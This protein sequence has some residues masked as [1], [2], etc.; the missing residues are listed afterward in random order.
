MRGRSWRHG[1][2]GSDWLYVGPGDT[3]LELPG[4]GTDTASIYADFTLPDNVE[5]LVFNPSGSAQRGT[6]NE[7]ANS[8]T[9]YTGND[10][11]QGLG[12]NDTLSGG[13]GNDTLDGGAGIDSAVISGTR[14]DFSVLRMGDDAYS[15]TRTAPTAGEV[16]SLL[17]MEFV[18]FTG[19]TL[20]LSTGGVSLSNTTPAENQLLSASSTWS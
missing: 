15:V 19:S 16:D 10:L 8:L 4:Q 20:A 13:A 7:L 12:G 3:I 18:Q 14:G 2:G 6:G 1:G 17:N 5:N 11:L 9:G